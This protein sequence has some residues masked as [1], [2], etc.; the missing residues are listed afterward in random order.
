VS[1]LKEPESWR[2]NP[3]WRFS[4]RLL[5][6]F[7]KHFHFYSSVTNMPIICVICKKKT[8]HYDSGH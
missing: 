3:R 8:A 1:Y 5:C 2:L 4:S 7:G 6:S